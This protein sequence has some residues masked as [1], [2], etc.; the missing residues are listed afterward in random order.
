VEIGRR[1]D[2][3]AHLSLQKSGDDASLHKT[4]ALQTETKQNNKTGIKQNKN[5]TDLDFNST[6]TSTAATIPLK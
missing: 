4:K 6:R 5:K 1:F 2:G 3:Q